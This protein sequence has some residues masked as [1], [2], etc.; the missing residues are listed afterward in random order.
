MTLRASSGDR[1]SQVGRIAGGVNRS[2][3]KGA[4]GRRG[5]G[6]R[7]SLGV[8]GGLLL[9]YHIDCRGSAQEL[10]QLAQVGR[11][12]GGRLGQLHGA[13]SRAIEHPEGDLAHS[14]IGM[15]VKGAAIEGL[16]ALGH[17]LQDIDLLPMPG[18]PGITDLPEVRIMGRV[19][20]S[21]T[22]R[23]ACTRPWATG[24]RPRSTARRARRAEGD[25]GGGGIPSAPP[26][27]SYH[28]REGGAEGMPWVKAEGTATTC[29]SGVLHFCS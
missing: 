25:V 21:C 17:R 5:R 12:H 10:S 23:S 3:G 16:S 18:M 15:E 24:R 20:M 13:T 7:I 1:L 2:G 8:R 9:L 22:T 26:S 6:I 14:E 29:E 4:R 11:T 27:L 19:L 28:R